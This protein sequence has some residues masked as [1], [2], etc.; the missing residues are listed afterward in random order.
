M[1]EVVVERGYVRTSVADVI[2]RDGAARQN[3]P[4]LGTLP[5]KAAWGLLAFIVMLIARRVVAGKAQ[6]LPELESELA[7][8]SLAPFGATSQFSPLEPADQHASSPLAQQASSSP[9]AAGGR[10][11]PTAEPQS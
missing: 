2:A 7:K 3:S 4:G 11:E 6:H 10:A 1:A 8:L 9:Q 5:P